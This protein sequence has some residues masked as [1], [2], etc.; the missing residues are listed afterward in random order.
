MN[1]KNQ[2]VDEKSMTKL[3]AV[4][5][6]TVRECNVKE[7]TVVSVSMPKKYAVVI[8]NDDVTPIKFVVFVLQHV[9]YMSPEQ[10]KSMVNIIQDKGSDICGIYSLDIAQTK[11]NQVDNL[12]KTNGFSLKC[13]VEC[14]E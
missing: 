4:S 5:T 8:W 13:S 1:R 12:S 7:D 14:R 11:K 10:S 6:S 9:F 3:D 2:Q